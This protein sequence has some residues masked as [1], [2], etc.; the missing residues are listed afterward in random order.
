M[1]I[2]AADFLQALTA[3]QKFLHE[4]KTTVSHQVFAEALKAQALGLTC[5][6]GL[7]GSLEPEQAT[8]ILA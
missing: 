6:I 4:F 7:L 3:V 8:N 2:S 1:G 5:N